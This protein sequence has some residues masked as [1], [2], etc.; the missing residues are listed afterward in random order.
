MSRDEKVRGVGNPA[1]NES[2][3]LP[4]LP[5]ELVDD[6]RIQKDRRE[7]DRN[8]IDRRDSD[9][10]EVETQASLGMS[11]DQQFEGQLFSLSANGC[12]I[13]LPNNTFE[14]G[15]TV[16]FTIEAVQPWK[17]TVRWVRGHEVGVEFDQPF[18]HSVFELIAQINQPATIS[19]AV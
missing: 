9:R 2:P 18:Y 13:R 12:A 3:K 15:D 6:A 1:C 16:W 7:Y 14:I 11:S 4:R 17:G 10:A 19:R 5:K 8:D